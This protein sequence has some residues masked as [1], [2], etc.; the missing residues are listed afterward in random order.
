VSRPV[1][2]VTSRVLVRLLGVDWTGLA[3]LFLFLLTFYLLVCC[4]AA[5]FAL[6]RPTVKREEGDESTHRH[7]TKK[8]KAR[9]DRMPP[10]QRPIP[11]LSDRTSLR[12]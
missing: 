7:D 6:V 5:L 2:I 1:H 3:L 12:E 4:V 8:Q 9:T 11:R 10:S